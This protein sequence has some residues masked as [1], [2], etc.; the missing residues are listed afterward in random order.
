[1]L[2]QKYLLFCFGIFSSLTAALPSQFD[3]FSFEQNYPQHL[4]VNN[5]ILLKINGKA[6]TVMDVV[7]KMDLLFYQQYPDLAASTLARYQFYTSAWRMIL[8]AVI[9]DYLIMED[10][11]EKK[12]TVN[13]GEVREELERIFGPDVVINIDK[14]GMSLDEAFDLLKTD[15]I[16]QK[17]TSI[18]VRSKAM[19]DVHPIVVKQRYEKVRAENPPLNYWVY[20]I[21]SIRGP[22][23]ETVAQKAYQ[24]ITE[25]GVSFEKVTQSVEEEGVELT[26]SEEYKQKESDL[27]LSYRAILETLSAGVA[28]APVSNQKVSRLFCFK[29]IEK[30]EPPAFKE[31]E[32][33]IKRELTQEAMVRYNQEYRQKL[34]K[35]HGLTET[36]LSSVIPDDLQP[37]N[38]R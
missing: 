28:S 38:L 13:D 29:G 12:I 31:V 3:E 33:G 4:I 10:A 5:R 37:F 21:L 11:E 19:T 23:H 6:I 18:M 17:M 27:S 36:Y 1:M 26:Y 30:M 34:R 14:L 25:Q 20:R 7:K 8:G 15:L 16:V 9:D 32:E 35:L 22:N 2:K 24:M